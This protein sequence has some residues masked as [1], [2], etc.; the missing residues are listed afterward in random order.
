MEADRKRY[1][2]FPKAV[3][4]MLPNLPKRLIGI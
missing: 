3:V 1:A 2:A 4:K